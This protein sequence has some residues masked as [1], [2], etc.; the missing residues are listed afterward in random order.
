[1]FCGGFLIDLLSC[2]AAVFRSGE[3]PLIIY[4]LSAAIMRAIGRTTIDS[5][6]P[7]GILGGAQVLPLE[8]CSVLGDRRTAL[9][10]CGLDSPPL[11]RLRSDCLLSVLARRLGL[12]LRQFDPFRRTAAR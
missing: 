5:R 6:L 7:F 2:W 4:M 11:R 8:A 10:H 12:L 1:M 3:H 9:L